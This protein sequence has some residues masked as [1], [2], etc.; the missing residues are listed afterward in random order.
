MA[1]YEN[2]GVNMNNLTA[3]KDFDNLICKFKTYEQ[4]LIFILSDFI[5]E[6]AEEWG[7]SDYEIVRSAQTSE[8]VLELENF[9]STE[10]VYLIDKLGNVYSA[11]IEV[12]RAAGK[13]WNGDDAYYNNVEIKYIDVE[14]IGKLSRF[15]K[16]KLNNA[17]ASDYESAACEILATIYQ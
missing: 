8:F 16:L 3:A 17:T 1:Q 10:C 2:Q 5:E 11:E 13:T 7:I 6:M 15:E 4:R 14:K 9:D 12:N